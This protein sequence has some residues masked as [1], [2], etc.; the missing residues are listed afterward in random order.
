MPFARIPHTPSAREVFCRNREHTLRY[1]VA[2]LPCKRLAGRLRIDRHDGAALVPLHVRDEFRCARH[3]AEHVGA[4]HRA[5]AGEIGFVDRLRKRAVH[6]CTVHEGVDPAEALDRLRC[7]PPAL[8]APG[9]VGS[10]LQHFARDAEC[11]DPACASSS[12]SIVRAAT[13]TP[14]APSRAASTASFTPSPAPDPGNHEARVLAQRVFSPGC[15]G[16]RGRRQPAA[17][18]R[19]ACFMSYVI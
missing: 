1:S 5:A 10:H 7:E 13:T 11:A 17:R 9:D 18:Q 2:G 8:R 19:R 6:E 4:E 15:R 3:R 12:F 14:R 16:P